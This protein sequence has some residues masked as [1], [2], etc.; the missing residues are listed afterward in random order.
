ML[1]SGGVIDMVHADERG[2]GLLSLNKEGL[3][4]LPVSSFR[5]RYELCKIVSDLT[6]RLLPGGTV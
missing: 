4:S 2:P 3:L 6:G 1:L 5:K